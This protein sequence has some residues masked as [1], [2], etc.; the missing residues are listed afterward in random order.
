MEFLYG[1]STPSPLTSNFLEFLRDSIDFGVFALHVDDELASI[2]ERERAT[3]H[4]ADQEVERLDSLGAAVAAAIDAAAKGEVESETAR[5]ATQMAT[6]SAEMVAVSTTSVRAQL[7][8]QLA[9]LTAEEAAQREA[10]FKALESLLMA[11]SPP[12]SAV[13]VRIERSSNRTYSA[14]RHG[15]TSFGL[16]WRVD[17]A[18]PA[19]HAFAGESPL[20]KLAPH[21]EVHAPEKSGWLKK[22]VKIKPTRL[23]RLLLTEAVDDGQ[24]VTLML[25]TDATGAIGVDFAI[26]LAAGTVTATRAGAGDDPSSGAFEVPAED[27]PGLVALAEKI[28]AAAGELTATRLADATLR[29]I[30]LR[31][32]PKFAPF[33]EQLVDFMAPIVQE[34]ARHSLTAT[35]LVLRRLITRERREEIFV[36]KATL[37]EKYQPLRPEQREIFE[38]L[39]LDAAPGSRRGSLAPRDEEDGWS[40]R[41]EV[42]RSDPPPALKPSRPPP[43]L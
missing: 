6:T 7:E 43:R 8:G 29:E 37:R 14:W 1:D 27:V 19:G 5:C 11:H 9:S 18:V 30:E 39:G 12:K 36:A 15:E 16:V 35:E 40:A 3:T 33:V 31:Q 10:C 34:V 13:S 24:T 4:A 2:H 17:L 22:E 28:R 26:N 41:A 38:R 32:A 23:D 20:E 25:R 42:P 21:A